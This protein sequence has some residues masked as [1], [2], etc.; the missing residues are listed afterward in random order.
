MKALALLLAAAA[1]P[2]GANPAAISEALALCIEVVEAASPA[3]LEASGLAQGQPG[4][5]TAP[6]WAVRYAA[7]AG[8]GEIRAE[9]T[10]SAAAQAAAVH[11][12]LALPAATGSEAMRWEK[13]GLGPV[14]A[15]KAE[16]FAPYD[17]SPAAPRLARCGGPGTPIYLSLDHNR[18]ARAVLLDVSS[19]RPPQNDP[20]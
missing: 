19:L 2:A 13:L 5:A 14:M 1:A 9:G 16:G 6:D 8:L 20:C 15:L 3:P 4:G 18:E 12:T 17:G 10:K 11:C 7:P